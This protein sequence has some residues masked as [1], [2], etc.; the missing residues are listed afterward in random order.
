MR[1]TLSFN[2]YAVEDRCQGFSWGGNYYVGPYN[3]RLMP[4]CPESGVS[5]FLVSEQIIF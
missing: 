4:N 5:D 3:I 2:F 1:I